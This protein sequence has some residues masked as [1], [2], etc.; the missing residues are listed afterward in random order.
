[1][2][3]YFRL[4]LCI[5]KSLCAAKMDILEKSVMRF[6]VL[7]TDLDFNMHMNNGR[8]LTI[9]DLGRLDMMIRTGL[10]KAVTGKTHAPVVGT[11]KIRYRLP[12]LPFQAYDLET[13]FVYWDDEW[14]YIEQRFVIAK[15]PKKGAVAAIAVVKVSLYDRINKR[16]PNPHEFLSTFGYHHDSPEISP[17]LQSFIQTEN[18]FRKLTSTGER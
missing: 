13:E 7:P 6:H 1:M 10:I 8:Y 11:A 4:I 17:F 12:L 3:L 14:A 16:R 2:N 18:E 5:I 9:M 15:G